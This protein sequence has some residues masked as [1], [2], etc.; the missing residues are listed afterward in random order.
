MLLKQADTN[1]V[2]IFK[3]FH[4]YYEYKDQYEPV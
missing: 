4:L 3:M 1:I 2:P